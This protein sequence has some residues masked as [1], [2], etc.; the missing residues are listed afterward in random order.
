MLSLFTDHF[1]NV[2]VIFIQNE[3]HSSL[4]N[5]GGREEGRTTTQKQKDVVY[6]AWGKGAEDDLF[7]DCGSFVPVFAL[8]VIIVGGGCDELIGKLQ[9]AATILI[10]KLSTKRETFDMYFD[11]G[12]RYNGLLSSRV[13]DDTP[14]SPFQHQTTREY[15]TKTRTKQR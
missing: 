3:V 8:S 6:L 9:A 11:V 1:E 12:R 7:G 15:K 10:L 4:F 2:F 13:H 14:V 5:L